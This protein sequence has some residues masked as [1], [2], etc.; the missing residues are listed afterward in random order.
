MDADVEQRSEAGSAADE[1]E[2]KQA[3]LDHLEATVISYV[4]VS[5]VQICAG[6]PNVNQTQH[7]SRRRWTIL[8]PTSSVTQLCAGLWNLAIHTTRQQAALDP[9]KATLKARF[10]VVSKHAAVSRVCELCCGA[11]MN[12]WYVANGGSLPHAMACSW[13]CVCRIM[14]LLTGYWRY[15]IAGGWHD[16][17]FFHNR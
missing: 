7:E 15:R 5:G 3:A 4:L 11:K 10:D 1:E 17:A 16:R 14:H 9:F 6:L 2:Q 8:K 12:S 13:C